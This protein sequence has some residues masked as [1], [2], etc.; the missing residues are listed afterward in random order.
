MKGTI[1]SEE[2]A[3]LLTHRSRAVMRQTCMQMARNMS[4]V[5]PGT[6][7]PQAAGAALED[8]GRHEGGSNG[9]GA[10]QQKPGGKGRAAAAKRLAA[11]AD[12]DEA[13]DDAG[14]IA[15]TPVITAPSTYMRHLDYPAMDDVCL[16]PP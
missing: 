2:L 8:L 7:R 1:R 10:P 5:L 12:D 6:S 3:R 9:A 15:S 16:G 4:R 14:A 11:G 13:E